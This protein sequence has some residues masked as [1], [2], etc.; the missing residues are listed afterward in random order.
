MLLLL[1][2]DALHGPWSPLSAKDRTA[3]RAAREALD[4]EAI[5]EHARAAPQRTL[6][7]VE[8]YRTETTTATQLSAASGDPGGGSDNAA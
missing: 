2:A 7:G 5:A 1:V 6:E 4:A 8:G 3:I